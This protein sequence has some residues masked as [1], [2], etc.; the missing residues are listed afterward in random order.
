MLISSLLAFAFGGTICA[1][2]QIL[3]DKTNL[4]PPRIL[5]GLVFVGAI[6]GALDLYQP[7]F[8]I[9]GA[10]ISVPLI[11]FGA[12]V[13]KGVKE[14]IDEFGALGIFTG[15]FSSAAIG[16]SATLI[17]AYIFSLICGGRPKRL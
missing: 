16:C 4:T 2:V 3:I 10:G 7:L 1:L 13:I 6:L 9:F 11:G 15:G 17:F 5:V 14:Q 8:E 12:N